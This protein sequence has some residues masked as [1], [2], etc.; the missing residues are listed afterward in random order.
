MLKNIKIFNKLFFAFLIILVVFISSGIIIS[1]IS[2][3][4]HNEFSEFYNHPFVV[5]NI[6][7]DIKINMLSIH[8]SIRSAFESE[9]MSE[10]SEYHLEINEYEQDVLNKLQILEAQYLGD[11]A[12]VIAL[13]EMFFAAIEVHHDILNLLESGMLEEAIALE[14]RDKFR[15]GGPRDELLSELLLV[16]EYRAQ[17]FYNEASS[18]YYKQRQVLVLVVIG[19]AVFLILI[20]IFLLRNISGPIRKLNRV[21]NIADDPSAEIVLDLNRK[22]EIGKVSIAFNDM[23]ERSRQ[24]QK[25]EVD[26]LEQNFSEL[27]NN[28]PIGA[29]MCTKSEIDGLLR[30]TRA[31]DDFYNLFNMEHIEPEATE[32]NESFKLPNK[33]I[34]QTVA[35]LLPGYKAMR[36]FINELNKHVDVIV[37]D[38]TNKQTIVLFNDVTNEVKHQNE[39][40]SLNKELEKK[41]E[42]R[43]A[44]LKESNQELE[45]FSYSI[46][47]DL[48][49]PLRHITGYIELFRKKHL[50]SIPDEGKRYLDIISEAA[51]GMGNL[52]DDL[53]KFF[54]MGKKALK[55]TE[56]S[57]NE[58][59]AEILKSFDINN[60]QVRIIIGD[61]GYSK[62][63][64]DL[65]KLVWQNL[66]DNSIKYSGKEINPIIEIGTMVTQQGNTF[67]VR[68][69]GVGFDMQYYDKIFAVFQRLHANAEF[70]GTG[71]G[72]ANAKRIIN[73]HGGK[74]WAEAEV[75]K[76][77]CFYFQI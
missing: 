32:K 74:I 19:S 55:I 9:N 11:T 70:P 58:M 64:P 52:I 50:E 66:I 25:E 20:S 35:E 27:F 10:I 67:F 72:L 21:I 75:G 3:N 69:N 29:V 60:N 28:M 26:S 38:S 51:S 62:G 63:D 18:S 39:I 40:E 7:K 47:H 5:T 4:I 22:D 30:I 71:I 59:V 17:E 76:G 43:T 1:S 15:N 57:N 36:V 44:A 24:R 45:E 68:D 48:R 13:R 73:M 46:S 34:H 6:I 33:I 23:I 54:R 12:K 31:N 41:V 8:S 42:S 49:A 61:L 77:A 16:S 65:M 56:Y 53:L 37:F 2:G 14:E